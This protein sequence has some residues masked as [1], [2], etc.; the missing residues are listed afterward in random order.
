ML[1]QNLTYG[2]PKQINIA[3]INDHVAYVHNTT[4][5][6]T[7]VDSADGSGYVIPYYS[8]ME[9][10]SLV[11][12]PAG[13]NK[14]T[15]FHDIDVHGNATLLK[16]AEYSLSNEKRR[17]SQRSKISADKMFKKM[18]NIPF[19]EDAKQRILSSFRYPSQSISYYNNEKGRHINIISATMT[20]VNGE[21]ILNMITN[22]I[23]NR[24]VSYPINSIYDID[25]ALGGC[26]CSR[27]N[28]STGEYE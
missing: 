9:N 2:V 12:A 10:A 16:W 20:V 3:A 22:D 1:A 21:L 27:L 26:W 18:C 11:D 15:I 19:D 25:Q 6:E 24:F 7:K 28:N 8:E 13:R 23:E 14:K 4:G 17:E 5:D